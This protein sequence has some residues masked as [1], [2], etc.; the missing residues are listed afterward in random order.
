M[1]KLYSLTLCSLFSLFFLNAQSKIWDFRDFDS[2][3]FDMRISNK[4]DSLGY[5]TI[6]LEKIK[7]QI[8]LTEETVI[9]NFKETIISY[10]D[11]SAQK[12]DSV[13]ITGKISDFPIDV[14]M[15]YEL[16][17]LYGSSNFPK[18]PKK[19]EIVIDTIVK[20]NI[21]E[22]TSSFYFIPYVKDLSKNLSYQ[23]SQFNPT[24]GVM[25]RI[26]FS[27]KDVVRVKIDN[28]EYD[29]YEI[30]LRGGV[31]SQ[32]I[33]IDIRTKNIMKITFEE[34]PWVFERL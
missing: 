30:K 32:N 12:M 17:R 27:I 13:L 31:A 34:T 10:T 26:D 23:Y 8:I 24:D 25:R 19:E 20:D 18:H 9:P 28:I 7:N 15:K 11:L 29:C 1:V 6:S 5:T 22:R 33:F 2:S 3:Q 14:T 4:G 21:I 16:N